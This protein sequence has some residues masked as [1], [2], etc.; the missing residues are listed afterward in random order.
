MW[1]I[2]FLERL[3]KGEEVTTEEIQIAGERATGK[4]PDIILELP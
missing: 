4:R 1:F 3:A 2:P